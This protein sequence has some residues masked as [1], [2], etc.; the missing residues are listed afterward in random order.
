M[1][2][3]WLSKTHTCTQHTHEHIFQYT[4]GVMMAACAT[5]PTNPPARAAIVGG[6]PHRLSCDLVATLP[7]I[8]TAPISAPSTVRLGDPVHNAPIPP[9]DVICRAACMKLSL[10]IVTGDE[11]LTECEDN[12]DYKVSDLQWS[13]TQ[14]WNKI[15]S[16]V[17]G[18]CFRNYP[19]YTASNHTSCFYIFERSSTL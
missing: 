5:P 12:N 19:P 17:D 2:T 11:Y 15:I 8:K 10:V 14:A 16:P 9:L 13:P 1:P 3:C 7:T 4:P 6:A 18:L